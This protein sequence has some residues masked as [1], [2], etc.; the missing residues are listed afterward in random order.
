MHLV[1]VE[2]EAV[3]CIL[4]HNYRG[5]TV[6]SLRF[7]AFANQYG[8]IKTG[9]GAWQRG[10]VEGRFRAVPQRRTPNSE[11]PSKSLREGGSGSR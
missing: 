1:G 10:P 8:A 11:V 7:I 4:Q 2:T 3:K 9:T 6:P 5:H